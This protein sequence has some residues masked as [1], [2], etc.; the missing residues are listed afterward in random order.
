MTLPS[1]KKKKKVTRLVVGINYHFFCFIRGILIIIRFGVPLFLEVYFL[2]FLHIFLHFKL[3]FRADVRCLVI[4]N[5]K[6]HHLNF[7]LF[8]PRTKEIAFLNSNKKNSHLTFCN[9]LIKI[10]KKS[11]PYIRY[12]DF[13]MVAHSGASA[14]LAPGVSVLGL[15]KDRLVFISI[16]CF[17]F[18]FFYLLTRDLSSVF[19]S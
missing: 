10:H 12:A 8:S 9:K 6:K 7:V 14:S 2:T 16:Y 19:C 18:Y 11:G 17:I 4:S 5:K 3:I 13:L 15:I 1:K